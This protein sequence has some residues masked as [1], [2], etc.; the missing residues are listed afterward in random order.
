MRYDRDRTLCH[1]KADA[2]DHSLPYERVI[3]LFHSF[4]FTMLEFYAA[5]NR[6]DRVW[7]ARLA[8]HLAG[9]LGVVLRHLYDPGNAQ[10]GS[11]RLEAVLPENLRD[12]VR[13][14]VRLCCG[15]TIPSGVIRL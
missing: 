13:G 11:K 10:I 7:S 12:R 9:D 4:S 14:A 1:F 3:G 15:D 2:A 8:S 6:E 5:W